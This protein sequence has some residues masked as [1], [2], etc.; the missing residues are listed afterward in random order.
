VVT[1][2]PCEGAPEL[3]VAASKEE[4]MEVNR[5]RELNDAFRTTLT[6]GCVMFTNGVNALDA[7]TQSS[8]LRRVAEFTEFKADN[9][10]YGE[11]D[12]GKIEIEGESYFW[13]IDCYD[14]S[15]ES[16]SP[17]PSDPA[18]TTRVLTIMRADEY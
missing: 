3:S 18:V 5:I 17:D 13:K 1:F 14:K 9:D 4:T 11:H 2:R 10:P 6:G 8:L 7:Q 16:G 12:F 15:L